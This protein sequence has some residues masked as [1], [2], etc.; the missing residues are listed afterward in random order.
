MKIDFPS[1]IEDYVYIGWNRKDGDEFGYFI[2]RQDYDNIA[3]AHASACA[4]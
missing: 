4:I 1:N 2:Q 3:F